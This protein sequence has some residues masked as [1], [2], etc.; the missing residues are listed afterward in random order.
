MNRPGSRCRALQCDTRERGRAP[1]FGVARAPGKRR[2]FLNTTLMVS[3]TWARMMGP[4]R[5]RYSSSALLVGK[6]GGRQQAEVQRGGHGQ[7]G[8]GGGL[9]QEGTQQP[10]SCP[11]G[12]SRTCA[13]THAHLR[14][15]LVVK[16]S[17]VYSTYRALRNLYRQGGLPSQ[18]VCGPWTAGGKLPLA[19]R[20]MPAESGQPGPCA[21]SGRASRQA[22]NPSPPLTC[23]RD[24]CRSLW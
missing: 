22:C 11:S 2:S 10:P 9:A 14:S 6:G 17:S 12:T 24:G 21:V 4:S 7:T 20:P 18:R 16:V 5:P 15:F 1:A 19:L 3:P 13:P 23:C 8:G